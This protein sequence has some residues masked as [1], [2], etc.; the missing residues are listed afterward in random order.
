MKARNAVL[1]LL[2]ALFLS[3]GS[4]TAS[5][6]LLVNG[7]F[8][9]GDL[10]GWNASAIDQGGIPTT[11]L[12]SVSSSSGG[13]HYAAFDTGTYATGPFDST[14][15]QSFTVTAAQPILSFDFNSMPTLSVDPTGT[16]TSP[17]RDSFV[18]SVF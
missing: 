6:D 5:A 14:L 2:F 9:T 16:G 4:G 11:P 7:N 13:I 18:A 12:I 8:A 1:A 17:F 3:V 15:S 10:T